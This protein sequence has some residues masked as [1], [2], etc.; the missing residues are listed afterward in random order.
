MLRLAIV[1]VFLYQVCSG[2]ENDYPD[3]SKIKTR[4]DFCFSTDMAVYD[5]PRS[6]SFQRV[7]N[8]FVSPEYD[9]RI[10]LDIQLVENIS[11]GPMIGLNYSVRR[12][13]E[14]EGFV[15]TTH[16]YEKVSYFIQS[17]SLGF[18]SGVQAKWHCFERGKSSLI[19]A[20][21]TY[22]SHLVRQE[23]GPSADIRGYPSMD[24]RVKNL[25]QGR[26]AL[27]YAYSL[28]RGMNIEPL[29]GLSFNAPLVQIAPRDAKVFPLSPSI[30][31]AFTFGRERPEKTA[32]P[33]QDSSKPSE[34]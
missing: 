22:Y 25:L 16:G 23:T 10:G 9:W 20:L 27:R 18:N 29:I 15:L 6:V 21:S 33:N 32:T 34:P 13:A 1:L 2:Q 11:L 5:A 31:L 26:L 7:F 8:R 28:D 3:F 17:K 30:G 4:F 19:L 12:N 14:S 24:G